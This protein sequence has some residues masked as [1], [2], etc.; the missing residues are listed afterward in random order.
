[1]VDDH[2]AGSIQRAAGGLHAVDG[3]VVAYGIDV[4]NDSPIARR[5]RAQMTVEAAGEH[6]TGNR[7]HG[8][9]LCRT[10]TQP[11]SATRMRRFPNDRASLRIQRE[12]SAAG[13]WIE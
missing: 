6:V 3:V 1:P 7:R 10:A 4:P 9:R 8:G 5:V 11:V 12:E 2:R 13:L